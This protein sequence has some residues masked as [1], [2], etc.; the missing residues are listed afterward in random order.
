VAEKKQDKSKMDN[1][2][3]LAEMRSVLAKYRVTRGITPEKLR[4]ILEELGPTYIKLGQIMSLHSDILPARY[5]EAL[6]DLNSNVTPMPFET[7]EEVINRSYRSDWR[8]IFSSIE[9]QPLGSAS[10]AQV[11]RATLKSGEQVVVKV[12]RKGVYDMMARDIGLLKR[13]V[14]LVPSVGSIKNMVDFEMV[15]DEMWTVAQEE[16]DFLKEAANLE[17]FARCNKDIRYVEVPRLYREYTTSR[18]LVMEYIDGYDIDDKEALEADGYDLDEIGSKLVNN[19]IKQVMDDGFFHADPHPGNVKIRDGK[20]V[21]IDMGMMGRLTEKD[22]KIMWEAVEGIA[23]NDIGRV[24]NAILKL[25][26]FWGQPEEGRLYED[27][28]KLLKRYGGA[29]MGGIDVA[30]F[31]QEV[32]EIMKENK[33]GLPHGMTMLA[34]G[35]SHMEGV[36][37]RIS[38]DI[39]MVQI[40]SARIREDYLEHF[41]LKTQLMRGGRRLYRAADKTVEI[42]SLAVDIMQEYLRGNARVKMKLEADREFSRLL[43]HLVRNVVMGLWVMAILIGSSIICT[44]DMQPR[45]LGIPA[46]GAFGFMLA[47]AICLYIFIRHWLTRNK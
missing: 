29:S 2:S 22:R 10:I 8:E 11:H 12:E 26:E 28:R 35:M 16:M 44:T 45:I 47:L 5:C 30:E 9:P 13:A 19:Y 46:L 27:L 24:E 34:R 14:R 31:L 18:V 23:V 43:R 15:L 25:G 38:P 3:R 39:N 21:W 32:L 42:P 17:E 20:I 37:A 7:V 6:M 33:I 40:A 36:L 1:R 4:G 41:D